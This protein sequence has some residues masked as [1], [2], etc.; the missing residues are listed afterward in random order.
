M[1]LA[2]WLIGCYLVPTIIALLLE[3]RRWPSIFVV[4]LLLGWTLI[5]W[6]VALAWA[7]MDSSEAKRAM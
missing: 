2:L 1:L 3:H 5:G 6:V 7:V 4:N